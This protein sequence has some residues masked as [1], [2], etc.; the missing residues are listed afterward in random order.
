MPVRNIAEEKC[1]S[2]NTFSC[3]YLTDCN[4][5][6]LTKFSGKYS[7]A[8]LTKDFDFDA[9]MPDDHLITANCFNQNV[10]E[11]AMFLNYK[12]DQHISN[13]DLRDIFLEQYQLHPGTTLYVIDI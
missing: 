5:Q 3:S 7:T 9:F 12:H 11:L 13:N 2:C 6:K 4:R 10:I 8:T 1:G